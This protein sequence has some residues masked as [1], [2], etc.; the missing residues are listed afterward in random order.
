MDVSALTCNGLSGSL[1]FFKSSFAALD[2]LIL[3]SRLN[4]ASGGVN[5][6]V[7]PLR[8]EA[9][10]VWSSLQKLNVKKFICIC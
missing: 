3:E 6:S 8:N 5:G 7:S 9:K 10:L 1:L 4:A 2:R